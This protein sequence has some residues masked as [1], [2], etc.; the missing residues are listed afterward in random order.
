L[1]FKKTKYWA[2]L[3]RV[4]FFFDIHHG[5]LFLKSEQNPGLAGHENHVPFFPETC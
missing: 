1:I 2:I 5:I 4:A 3:K